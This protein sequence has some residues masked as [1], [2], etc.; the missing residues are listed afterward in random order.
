MKPHGYHPS[1]QKRS[2]G[3]PVAS[4]EMTNLSLVNWFEA[5]RLVAEAAH[6]AG[7]FFLCVL[8]NGL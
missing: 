1:E 6:Q 5:E 3:T 4:V 7:C 2:P 8:S